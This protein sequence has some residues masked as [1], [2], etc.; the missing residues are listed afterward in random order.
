RK[1][2]RIIRKLSESCDKLPSALFITGVS[3]REEYPTFGGGYG[4]IYRAS[5]NNKPVALKHLRHFLRGTESHRIRL[6]LFREALVWRELHHPNILPFIGIDRESFPS[7]LCMVSPWMEH[8][9]ILKYLEVHGHAN[10]FEIA[11]GLQ[12][13]HSRNIV[14]GDLR[15]ANI[16][17]NEDWSACLAD[18]ELSVFSDALSMHTSTRAG[19]LYWMAPE[20]IVPDRSGCRF[21]RTLASDVYAFGCTCIELC[22]LQPPFSN[23]PMAWECAV[24]QR[25]LEGKRPERPTAE[26]LMTDRFW[27]CITSYWGQDPATRPSVEVIVS[28]MLSEYVISRGPNKDSQSTWERH[29]QY[30]QPSS[31]AV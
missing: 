1:A 11:Q 15:G 13:L 9:T 30:S 28:D 19:S 31:T 29:S 20:L 14:H 26:P 17:I 21:T 12:Y 22:T 3:E 24:I 7:S 16:L 6:N 4:D 18:F 25:V 8:G 23:I 27:Q 10:V 2:R 5:H